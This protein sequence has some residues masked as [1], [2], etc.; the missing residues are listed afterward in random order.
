MSFLIIN[1]SLH[2][3]IITLHRAGREDINADRMLDQISYWWWLQDCIEV[4]WSQRSV[5][6]FCK[7]SST[8]K[9]KTNVHFFLNCNAFSVK[10]HLV[11]V[12]MKQTSTIMFYGT[13]YFI[14]LITP[15][16]FYFCVQLH[17]ISN[18]NFET[19]SFNTRLI[20]THHKAIPT[21]KHLY[22]YDR[23]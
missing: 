14:T 22:A 9:H 19:T 3:R 8:Y 13:I 7:H 18:T 2:Q 11:S 4:Q 5:A 16:W 12:F 20:K 23:L 17:D 6:G 10:P 15:E 1:M 21:M